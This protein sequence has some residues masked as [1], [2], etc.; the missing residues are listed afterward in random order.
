MESQYPAQA[1]GAPGNGKVGAMPFLDRLQRWA[2][3]RPDGTAVV[4][5]GQRLD[6][7]GLRDAAADLVPATPAVKVLSAGN[8]PAFAAEFAAAVAGERQCAVLDP[9]WPQQLQ[10]E[11]TERIFATFPPDQRRGSGLR[12]RNA[13]GAELG[14]GPPGSPFLIG[15]TSGTT[16][17]PKAF[18]RSR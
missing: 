5:A 4:L 18:T 12:D 10:D 1:A 6:W 2:D 16:T 7:A 15:L 8:L 13:F 9:S 3:E 17:V 14:D 11:I